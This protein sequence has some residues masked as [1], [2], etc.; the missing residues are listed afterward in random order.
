MLL[1]FFCVEKGQG[2]FFFWEE[3]KVF[4]GYLCYKTITSQ[5]GSFEAQ[6]KNFISWKSYGPFARYSNFCI[7]NLPMIY[8]ICDVLMSIS[9]WDRVHLYIYIYI[10]THTYIYIYIHIYV[11][12]YIYTYIYIYIHVYICICLLSN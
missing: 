12:I 10:Y 8:Q 4:K 6:I 1:L 3:I 9:T 2:V 5:S 11:Y 7:L